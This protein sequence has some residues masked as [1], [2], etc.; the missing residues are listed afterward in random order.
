MKGRLEFNLPDEN[1]EFELAVNAR[2]LHSVIVEMDRWLRSKTK[3]AP[4]SMSED[5]YAALI[6]CRKQLR[7]L[8][9]GDGIDLD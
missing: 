6:E 3:Y 5:T 1:D 9:M 4:D 7:E 8:A 2:K